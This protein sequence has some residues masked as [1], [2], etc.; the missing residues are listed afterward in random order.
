MLIRKNMKVAINLYIKNK[1]DFLLN[2]YIF[3]IQ[4][5]KNAPINKLSVRKRFNSIAINLNLPYMFC[6]FLRKN[7]AY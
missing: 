2:E 3:K 7:F 1:G 6:A 5:G 4:K